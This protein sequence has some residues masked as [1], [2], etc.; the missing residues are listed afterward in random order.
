[1]EPQV[2]R[3]RPS[4]VS[5]WSGLD[6]DPSRSPYSSWCTGTPPRPQSTSLSSPADQDPGQAQMTRTSSYHSGR[7]RCGQSV[8]RTLDEAVEEAR[9]GGLALLTQLPTP[10]PPRLTLPGARRPQGPACPSPWELIPQGLRQLPWELWWR[11]CSG[12]LTPEK[13]VQL[14]S[15]T[16]LIVLLT[17]GECHRRGLV[18][19]LSCELQPA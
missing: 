7:E 11:G 5:A 15:P 9:I 6:V 14:P 16:Y 4:P 10:R 17:P 3:D 12:D 8:P 13:A 1:M 18:P 19:R 2:P